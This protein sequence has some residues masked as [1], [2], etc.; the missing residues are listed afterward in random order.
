MSQI[1]HPLPRGTR[2]VTVLDLTDLDAEDE[3]RVT[4]AG[5][6]GRIT[7]VAKEREDGSEGFCY[8]VEFDNQAWFVLDD[9]ELDDATRFRIQD[10][11]AN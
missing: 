9:L 5:S 4:T 6:V 7:G 11:S 3:E 8:D 10:A 2:I 1:R